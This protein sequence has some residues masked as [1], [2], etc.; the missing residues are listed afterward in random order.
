MQPPATSARSS[1]TARQPACAS[2]AAADSPLI[3]LPITTTSASGMANP[4]SR[5]WAMSGT[6]RS[7]TP[8]GAFDGLAGLAQLGNAGGHRTL[9]EKAFDT[10]HEAI[11]HGVVAP[12]QRL[13]IEELA[14]VMGMSPMP[15]REAIRRLDS[16]GL[17]ENVPHRGAR[18]AALTVDDLLEVY[19]ARLELEPLAVQR[20]ALRISDE[21]R[22]DRRRA[23]RRP[24][25]LL[26]LGRPARL[27]GGA[28]R[29][30]LHALPRGRLALADPAD[31][32]ALAVLGAL[33]LRLAAEPAGAGAAPRRARGDPRGLHRARRRGRR[34]AAAQPPRAH[35]Q[36]GRRGDGRSRALPARRLARGI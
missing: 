32:A 14:E 5:L 27:V 29:V 34:Q 7:A 21:E 10:L 15:I 1:T 13:P 23:A 16:L 8:A 19:E 12:G 22:G 24:P 28:Q 25:A 36:R 26:P 3:P 33:P 20:A 31:H 11:V 17:V 35:G 18:A 30:P 2:S 4:P 6:T 9:A